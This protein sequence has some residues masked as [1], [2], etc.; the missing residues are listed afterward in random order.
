MEQQQQPLPKRG[1]KASRPPHETAT[2]QVLVEPQSQPS[3]PAKNWVG[4][5]DGRPQPEPGCYWKPL[6]DGGYMYVRDNFKR[7]KGSY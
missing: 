7:E 6:P 2:N 1:R 4:K 5:K 3:P